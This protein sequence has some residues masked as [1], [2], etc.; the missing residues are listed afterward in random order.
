MTQP[1]PVIE[2]PQ[3]PQPTEIRVVT[4]AQLLEKVRE[5]SGLTQQEM[6]QL[7]RVGRLPGWEVEGQCPS[8]PQTHVIY[9]MFA[10]AD[11]DRLE[12]H[13]PGDVRVYVRPK[14][15]IGADGEPAPFFRFV[16]NRGQSTAARTDAMPIKAWIE[17]VAFEFAA[18]V[19]DDEEEEEEEEEDDEDVVCKALVPLPNG[20]GAL[21][22]CATQLEVDAKFCHRCAAPVRKCGNC[23]HYADVLDKFCAGCGLPLV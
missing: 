9:A 10:G 4:A 16:L 15:F 11:G 3:P 21:A 2:A 17:D 7:R 14:N 23:G 6:E 22:P 12:D 1:G 20:N 18:S 8:F 5:E 13:L 19:V